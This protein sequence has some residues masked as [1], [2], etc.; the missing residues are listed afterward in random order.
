[1]SKKVTH[2]MVFHV[3]ERFLERCNELGLK[4]KTADNYALEFVLGAAHALELVGDERWKGLAAFASFD[5]AIRGA[6]ACKRAVYLVASE[7]A[8]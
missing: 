3:S 6:H 5:V 7:E 4:G 1:M 2:S 8:S